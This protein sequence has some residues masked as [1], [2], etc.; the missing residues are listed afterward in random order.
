MTTDLNK[1]ETTEKGVKTIQPNIG[2]DKAV[3][4]KDNELLNAYLADL[5]VLYI[6]TRKY[7]WNVAGPSFKEYHE[8]FEEQYK[9]LEEMIDQVA[10]RIRTLGGK[11]LSTMRDFIDST[12]LEE[13]H[14][15]EV[16]TVNM[17]E[18]LLADHEK[19]VRE[20]RDDVKTTDEDL[21]DAGTADFLTGLM[22]KHEKMAWMLRKYLS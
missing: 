5:H 2:L 10:E 22:E 15:G 14:S 6:K 12:S 8:F 21:D 9:Q 11:P 20:L 18:R 17:F 1:P 4:K 19:V 13:D 16:K 3:L 7:H